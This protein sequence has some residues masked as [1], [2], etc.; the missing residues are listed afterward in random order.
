MH[1]E[2]A[3]FS[4][5][6][7]IFFPVLL[8]AEQKVLRPFVAMEK[9]LFVCKRSFSRG[10]IWSHRSDLQKTDTRRVQAHNIG[11]LNMTPFDPVRLDPKPGSVT[12]SGMNLGLSLFYR[13]TKHG[14]GF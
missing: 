2:G 6:K 12:R 3:L 10:L 8:Q 11:V 4:N 7:S 14:F 5:P 13:T 9:L 1:P